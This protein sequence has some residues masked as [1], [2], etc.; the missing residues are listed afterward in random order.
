M[1]KEKPSVYVNKINK[2]I[3]N[4]Q[5]IYY[6]K[7]ETYTQKEKPV[8]KDMEKVLASNKRVSYSKL[9]KFKEGNIEEKLEILMT[10]PEY[11]FNIDLEVVTKDNKYE[12]NV[13]GKTDTDLITTESELIPIKDITDIMIKE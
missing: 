6:S 1:K 8:K 12:V 5:G 4:S 13:A 9:D 3:K 7:N 2:V 10:L 11:L